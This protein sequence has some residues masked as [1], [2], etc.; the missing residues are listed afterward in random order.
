MGCEG[1]VSPPWS[2][3]RLAIFSVGS[4][5]GTG[6]IVYSLLAPIY[7][8]TL[9]EVALW[10]LLGLGTVVT[11]GYLARG[12]V[13]FNGN[14]LM[15]KG[16][17]SR[18]YKLNDLVEFVD[19]TSV[20]NYLPLKGIP[21]LTLLTFANFVASFLAFYWWYRLELSGLS[22]PLALMS[23]ASFLS[24][25]MSGLLSYGFRGS[26]GVDWAFSLLGVT[27]ILAGGLALANDL[28]VSGPLTGLGIAALIQRAFKRDWS[29]FKLKFQDGSSIYLITTKPDLARRVREGL[30]LI[31]S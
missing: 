14:R 2:G 13:E 24:I 26:E 6:G 10:L 20:E 4:A 23:S 31:V 18:E 21:G 29:V 8:E 25:E 1:V 12:E 30:G 15:I 5:L 16:L 28:R 17:L 3:L 7:G 27:L 22:V 9:K 19:V 11:A